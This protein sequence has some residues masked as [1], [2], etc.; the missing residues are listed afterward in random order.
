VHRSELW[1][2][3]GAS[4][5]KPTPKTQNPKPKTQ[6]PYPIGLWSWWVTRLLR[7]AI[8]VAMITIRRHD[9]DDESIAE[10]RMNNLRLHSA[11]I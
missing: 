2:V 9:N 3:A 1:V 6:H 5:R 4:S 10:V 11:S 8:Y 7:L